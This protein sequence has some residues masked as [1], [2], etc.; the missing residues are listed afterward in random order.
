MDDTGCDIQSKAFRNKK[1]ITFN[2]RQILLDA[3]VISKLSQN[4][5]LTRKNLD[6]Y[7]LD[8]EEFVMVLCQISYYIK[9]NGFGPKSWQEGPI[10]MIIGSQV[11]KII[12]LFKKGAI[13]I[14]RRNEII[15]IF[16]FI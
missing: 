15:I 16:I 5:R 13:K 7:T 3:I 8:F 14:W 6:E 11:T 9:A 4:D 10:E 1:G 12:S 2:I